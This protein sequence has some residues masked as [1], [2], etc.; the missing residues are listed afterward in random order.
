MDPQR[1]IRFLYPPF[2]FLGSIWLGVGFDPG[3]R[4]ADLVD[5][6]PAPLLQDLPGVAGLLAGGGLLIIVVG[7]VIGI[8]SHGI[9]KLLSF[10]HVIPYV[11]DAPIRMLP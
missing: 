8:L 4:I 10:T 11:Y 7:Y 3:I 5:L 1:T 2:V 9:V 6:I